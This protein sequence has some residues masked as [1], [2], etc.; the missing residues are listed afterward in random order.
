MK[1]NRRTSEFTQTGK[2]NRQT[3]QRARYKNSII[4]VCFFFFLR[5]GGGD[6]ASQGRITGVDGTATFVVQLAFAQVG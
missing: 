4:G 3:K 1:T 6:L 2:T 5:Y